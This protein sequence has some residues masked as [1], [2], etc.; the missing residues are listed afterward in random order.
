[1][2]A[3][4]ALIAVALAALVVGCSDDPGTLRPSER[5]TLAP[6]EFWVQAQGELKAAK[7]TPLKVPGQNFARRQLIWMAP[8]GSAVKQGDVV[9]KFSA[10][11]A[12]LELDKAMLDLQRNALAR[13]GKE[14]ELGIGLDRVDVELA[15]AQSSLVIAR[16][17]AR[18]DFEA[19]ARNTVL[20][21]VQDERFLGE[22]TG[23]LRW[24]QGQSAQRGAAEL[25][26]LGVQR[27]SIDANADNR[28]S[29]LAALELRAA[30]D[31]VFMLI[32]A[33]SGN[34]AQVGEQMWAGGDFASLPDVG[35]LEVELSLPQQ[36]A[37]GLA[38]GQRVL[39]NPLGRP[40]QQVEGELTWV[41]SAPRPLSRQSPAKYVSVKASVP[42]EGAVRHGWVPG[43]AFSGRIILLSGEPAITVANVAVSDEGGEP[44]VM[45]LEDGQPVR[46][47]LTLGVRGPARVQVLSG[48]AEGEQV[49]LGRERGEGTPVAPSNDATA[50]AAP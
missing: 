46:R 48:L 22:K 16:R 11:Q 25:D 6:A 38:P 40:D 15:Q 24:R 3:R 28:R 30:H 18:A 26:V 19:L 34:R 5:V 12:Q 35:S 41:A 13:A 17:Y 7:A 29:D 43:Q 2:I 10:A 27:S 45:V 8:D 14:S 32:P 39:L 36:E 31:G 9:A 42:A 21:A 1:L 37:Q 33:W 20:D 44:H 49:L 50:G 23:V 4:N 47:V